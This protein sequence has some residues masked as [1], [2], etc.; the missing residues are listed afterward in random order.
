[1]CVEYVRSKLCLLTS[2]SSYIQHINQ[3]IHSV[4]YSTTQIIKYNS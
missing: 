4:K 1:M 2:L 3:Q